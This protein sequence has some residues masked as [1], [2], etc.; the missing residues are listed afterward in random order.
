MPIAV[1]DSNSCQTWKKYEAYQGNAH[2]MSCS[3]KAQMASIH[4]SMIETVHGL[5]L[6]TLLQLVME[7]FGLVLMICILQRFDH[8][9]EVKHMSIHLT[10]FSIHE[11]K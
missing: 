6:G 7:L 11:K 2:N 10:L 8:N 5:Q 3:Q 9:S 4:Y 1:S